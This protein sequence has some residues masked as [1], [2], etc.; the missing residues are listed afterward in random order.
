MRGGGD[1]EHKEKRER[2]REEAIDQMSRET[3]DRNGCCVLQGQGP[4]LFFYFF[5][6]LFFLF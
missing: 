1:S 6:F 2:E 5:Y 3:F 4:F